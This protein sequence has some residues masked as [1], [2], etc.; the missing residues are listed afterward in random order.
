MTYPKLLKAAAILAILVLIVVILVYA[1]PLLVPL[2]FGAI[3]SMLLLPMVK[4]MQ[5]K[6]VNHAV[7]VLLS[8]LLFLSFFAIM[9]VLVGWQVSD[10]A[11]NSS[12]ISEQ[13][14]AKFQQ[15]QEFIAQKTGMP[16]EKMQ[17][18]MKEQQA[19]SPGK[20]SAMITGFISGLGGFLTDTILVLVYIFLFLYLRSRLK[21]F[22]LK[23]VPASKQRDASNTIASGQKVTQQ[24]I[25]GLFMMIVCLWI[26]YGIGF[27]IVGVKSAFFFAILCGLLEIVPFVGNL[28]GT[29]LTVLL[30]LAQGGD[31]NM[32][33]GILVTYALVQFIQTYI[34]EPLVVGAEVNI[35]PLFT[36]VGIVAGELLWGVPGMILAIPLLGI[37]KI[38]CEHVEPLK[39]YAFLIGQEKKEDTGFKKK[40]KDLFRR[41]KKS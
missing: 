5:A 28:A 20:A 24:Y 25:G 41:K 23:L 16:K 13:V 33:I 32:V 29:A 39:P 3:I 18:M 21:T 22:V 15:A 27:S 7:A 36:I 2:T 40:I 8:I 31:A 10:L 30:S 14:S 6:R 4:W 37:A 1:K 12:N 11:D 26:M 34:L 9:F 38:I 17:Q 35:N 19:S